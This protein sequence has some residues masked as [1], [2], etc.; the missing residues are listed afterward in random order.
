MPRGAVSVWVPA[1]SLLVVRLQGH[2]EAEFA[3]PIIQAFDGLQMTPAAHLFFD[4]EELENYESSLRVELTSR[5]FPEREK[6]ASSHVLVRSKLVAM[7]VSVANLALGGIVNSTSDRRRFKARL[8]ACLFALRVV[9]FSSGVL[10]R[11]GSV[12]AESG[13]D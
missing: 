5:L 6:L 11:L 3:R 10:D 2:G 13:A 9:G 7:G 12:R 1:P 8:D 4:A